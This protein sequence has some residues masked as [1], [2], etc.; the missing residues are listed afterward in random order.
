MTKHTEEKWPFFS[1]SHKR[2]LLRRES[3]DNW[4]GTFCCSFGGVSEKIIIKYI[5][6]YAYSSGM[7]LLTAATVFA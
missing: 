6:S 7:C 5:N 3:V 2:C 1:I 4:F